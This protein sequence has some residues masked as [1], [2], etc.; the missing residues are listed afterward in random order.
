MNSHLTMD[1]ASKTPEYFDGARSDIVAMLPKSSTA[2]IIE[3]GC[4]NGST[5]AIAKD[6]GKCGRYV[7]V[8]VDETA[9]DIARASLDVVVHG[10]V[11]TLDFLSL[12]PPFD[13]AILSEVLEHLVDPWGLLSRLN[14]AMRPGALIF[15][16]SPNVANA[17]LMRQ[18]LRNRFDYVAEGVMDR[19]HLRWFTSDTFKEM[20]EASGFETVSVGPLNRPS[21]KWRALNAMTANRF[22]HL[23]SSQIMY[24]GRKPIV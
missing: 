1:Y 24:C 23:A 20:F 8:D 5:G 7:G 3:I 15:A 11:E 4:G 6:Q 10:N 17:R 12:D 9:A 14:D 18:L 22:A 21:F 13:A 19:T 16:S 2:S